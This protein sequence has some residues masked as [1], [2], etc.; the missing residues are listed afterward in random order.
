MADEGVGLPNL[1]DEFAP[2]L[3]WDARKGVRG[4]FDDLD[5]IGGFRRNGWH[6]GIRMWIQGQSLVKGLGPL[7]IACLFLLLGKVGIG[8]ADGQGCV[9]SAGDGGACGLHGM[10]QRRHFCLAPVQD[11]G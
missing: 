7:L 3:A 10:S 5:G 2:L 11:F 6:S 1:L 4:Q 9:G 8:P